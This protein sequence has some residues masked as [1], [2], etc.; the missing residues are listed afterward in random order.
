[1]AENLKRRTSSTSQMVHANEHRITAAAVEGQHP[2]IGNQSTVRHG[3][4]KYTHPW[5]KSCA[6]LAAPQSK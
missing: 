2:R 1:M 6:N 3:K 4:D 5:L